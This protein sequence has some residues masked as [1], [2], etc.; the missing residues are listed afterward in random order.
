MPL[1]CFMTLEEKIITLITPWLVPDYFVMEVHFQNR[2]PTA[3]LQVILDGVVGIG[4]ETCA[5]VSRKL[6]EV[7][8]AE[9]WIAQKLCA[10]GLLTRNRPA[11]D[12]PPPICPTPRAHP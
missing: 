6:S 11:P 12:R 2:R 8:E 4:I 7:L 3:K 10:G 5:E 1:F 9:D